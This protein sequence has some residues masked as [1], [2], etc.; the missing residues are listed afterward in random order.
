VSEISNYAHITSRVPDLSVR[1]VELS[2]CQAYQSVEC[3]QM[4]SVSLHNGDSRVFKTVL[5]QNLVIKRGPDSIKC[6]R[7]DGCIVLS[8]AG[9]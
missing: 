7:Y 3:V 2:V 9:S 4:S 1:S 5:S 6:Y 8:P